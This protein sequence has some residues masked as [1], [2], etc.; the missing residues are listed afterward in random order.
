MAARNDLSL[1][2]DRGYYKDDWQV[3]FNYCL[4]NNETK[5]T[6]CQFVVVVVGGGEDLIVEDKTFIRCGDVGFM[7]IYPVSP[8]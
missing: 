1:F 4:K 6:R 2:I 8:R 3:D 7:E 5:K